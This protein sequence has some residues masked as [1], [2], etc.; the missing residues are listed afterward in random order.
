M[1]INVFVGNKIKEYRER[2]GWTQDQ[3]ADK[4]DTT[5]QT[6][7]RYESGV[8]KANQDVLFELSNIFNVSINNFFPDSDKNEES[9]I[10]L[11]AAHIDD[12]ASDE[13]IKDILEYIDFKRKQRKL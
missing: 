12:D 9:T 5:R 3:L 13:E 10:S 6:V 2:R 1:N 11:L 7:S 4:L 8:R